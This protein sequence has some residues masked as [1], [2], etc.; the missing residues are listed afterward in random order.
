MSN[1]ILP[2]IDIDFDEEQHAYSLK[3]MRLQSVTQIM[4][5]L[6]LMAYEGVSFSALSDAADR[7]TRAH[8]QVE[9]IVKYGIEEF[10][11][12]TEGYIRAFQAFQEA[13]SPVW[14]ASEYRCF[15][16]NMMYAGTL[17][18]IGFI[19]PND[20]NGVDVVDLKCTAVFHRT[21]LECQLSAYAEALKSHGVKVRERYGLQLMKD[22]KYRFEKLND[23]YKTFIHAL[24]L[25]NAMA[26]D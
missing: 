15:H 19:T 10:D 1:T 6:S 8:A 16:K 7:G 5:P 21:L 26:N 24:A 12:D 22:G 17:D 25:V 20:G 9:A 11:D 2:V 14:L 18:L 3:G 13:L 23:G 4:R